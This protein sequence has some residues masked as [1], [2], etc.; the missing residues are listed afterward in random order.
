MP[1]RR[2][3]S[4]R[5][6]APGWL[7]TVQ[8]LGRIGAQR[9]GMPVAGAM[10]P[11]ALRLANRLVGNRDDAA[12]LE[13]TIQGPTLLC[14][15]DA[16]VAVTGG[17][18]SPTL[19]GRHLPLWTSFDVRR[20][21]RL[22]FGAR[23]S[24]ARAYLAVAGGVDVPS[25]LG[26]R[27]T[28]LA[29][30]TGGLEGRALQQ[31]DVLAAGPRRSRRSVAGRA[32]PPAVRP[33][34]RTPIDLRL[35]PGPQRDWFNEEV[36]ALLTTHAYTIGPASDRMGYRLVGP[37][38]AGGAD[39]SMLSEAM[40]LGALQVPGDGQP[41]LLMA[42][43]QTTGGYP[44]IAVLATADIGLAAQGAPGDRLHVSFVAVED[45]RRLLREQR[46][47]VDEA[48]PPVI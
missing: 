31:G 30:R 6:V 3:G 44:V 47:A 34:Y 9:Y 7:T 14:E 28:H 42:D 10:D 40:P 20:G 26:S 15:V 38:L 46:A 39:R 32:V 19:D 23:R 1:S 45:A 5:V 8:D 29:S 24:G 18:L 27:A 48:L 13:V 41:I 16:L 2:R 33:T 22:A 12:G 21:Q 11:P 17:D 35:V 25:V 4:F 36:V 37:P 43:R